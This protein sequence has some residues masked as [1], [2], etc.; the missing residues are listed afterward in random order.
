M[1]EDSKGNNNR[2]GDKNAYDKGKT[3]IPAFFFLSHFLCL[4]HFLMFTHRIAHL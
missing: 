1:E 4:S 2:H 3:I